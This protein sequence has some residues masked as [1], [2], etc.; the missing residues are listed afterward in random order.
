[1]RVVSCFMALILASGCATPPGGSG[2]PLTGMA[3]PVTWEV[4]DIG[5]V[6]SADNQRVRWSYLIT[7]RNT[8][9][10]VIRFER[11]ERALGTAG[12]DA[13]GG[14]PTT[15]SYDRTLR[16]REEARYSATDNWGWL[17]GAGTN[18]AFGGAATLHAVAAYRTF[19]GKDDRGIPVSVP[20]QVSLNPST[21]LLT[22]PPT[23]PSNLPPRTALRSTD[24]LTPL[25]GSWRGSYRSE[26]SSLNVPLAATILLDGTVNLLENEPVTYRFSRTVQLKDGGLEYSGGREQGALSLHEGGGRRMLVGR[27][28]PADGRPYVVY[29]EAATP[30]SGPIQSVTPSPPPPSS[31]SATSSPASA[32]LTSG[33]TGPIDL[34]GSYQGTVSGIRSDHTSYSDRVTVAVVQAGRE[35]SGTWSTAT[36]AGTL[37]G[38]VLG[39][40][41]FTFRFR[42]DSPCVAEYGGIGTIDD[43]GTRLA[44]SYRGGSCGGLNVAASLVITR[45][46]R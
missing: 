45:E 41:S 28:S 1:M 3:G 37:T 44:A 25:V 9:D 11:I 14:T 12:R 21:G 15:Q 27:V 2:G 7:L 5:R 23:A 34:T 20:V 22:K 19:S 6:L 10:R 42:Q 33:E 38:T 26:D 31:S 40:T 4:S 36:S 29:L 17:A 16:P 18:T 24:G 46:S 32:S 43:S 13:V 39:R 30:G 35:F 8:G